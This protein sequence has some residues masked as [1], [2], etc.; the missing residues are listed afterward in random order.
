ML[1][2][3][4]SRYL[5]QIRAHHGMMGLIQHLRVSSTKLSPRSS[6]SS[7]SSCISHVGASPTSREC[8]RVGDR[9]CRH[10][11]CSKTRQ[12]RPCSLQTLQSLRH[13]PLVVSRHRFA[14]RSSDCQVRS[15]QTEK[16]PR[17]AAQEMQT[18]N[19]VMFVSLYGKTTFLS[20][21]RDRFNN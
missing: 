2:G 20:T 16:R 17:R 13:I 6:Y 18:S 12:Y 9:S 21:T 5:L 10:H 8:A 19:L 3:K 4:L 1:R 11:Q 15:P 14:N 7:T